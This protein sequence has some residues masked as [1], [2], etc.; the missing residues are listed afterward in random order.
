MGDLP[1]RAGKRHR[2]PQ[3]TSIPDPR[4][5]E[6][7]P[8]APRPSPYAGG[9]DLLLIIDAVGSPV[10]GPDDVRDLNQDGSVNDVDLRILANLL[11]RQ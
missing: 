11:A 10:T 9:E 4:R 8:P 5:S 2:P 3:E 6:T 7:S 1:S